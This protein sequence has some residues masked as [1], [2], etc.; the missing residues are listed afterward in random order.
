MRKSQIAKLRLVN[1]QIAGT[2]FSDPAEL[3]SWL[4]AV[5]AQDYAMAKWAIGLRLNHATE[6]TVEAAIDSGSIVRTHVMRPTWHFVAAEDIRWML[7]LTATRIRSACGSWKRHLELDDTTIA[8][9]NSIIAKALEGGKHLT[10][11][12]LM[13]ELERYGIKTGPGRAG[14]LMLEA[15]VEGIVCNGRRRGKQFTYSLLDETVPNTAKLN[16]EAALAKLAER[17]FASHGPA[18]LAD[19]AWWSGLSA[20]DV[21][22]AHGLIK[23]KL[24]SEK[25]DEKVYWMS[26]S[27]STTKLLTKSVHLLPSFDELTI[28]YKDRSASVAPELMKDITVGHAIFRPIIVVDG[29]VVGIW[30]RVIKKDR[31]I[32]EAELILRSKNV[33]T[34]SIEKAALGYSSFEEQKCHLVCSS[35]IPD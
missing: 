1:Q 8:K 11:S 16:K 27:I 5:Q 19:F 28:S 14:Y 13:T 31:A 12:E 9:S 30:K 34:K 15:E 29:H 25:I 26:N 17:Y 33:D 2:K 21:A 3:V 22:T 6:K 24:I 7:E 35:K 20:A 4:G 18:T 10:R 23:P 32:I